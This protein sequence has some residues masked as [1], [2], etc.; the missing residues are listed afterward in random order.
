MH[1]PESISSFQ[2]G[3]LPCRSTLQQMLLFI[4]N[5]INAKAQRAP[6]DVIYLDIKKAF[7]TVSHTILL[8]KLKGYGIAGNLLLWFRAYLT[9]RIQ[10]VR[11]NDATSDFMPVTS[12]VPQG[13]ILGPLLFVL[14][15]N[16][17]PAA[18]KSAA[19]FLFADDTKCMQ[20]TKNT[21][22]IFLL[23]ADLNQIH[24]W[25]NTSDLFFNENKC[26]HLHFWDFWNSDVNYSIGNKLISLK[27]STKDLGI[28]ITNNLNWSLHYTHITTKSY[29]F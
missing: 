3:F 11:I 9:D 24:H 14:F 22:D 27:D 21:E 23:Q 18:A 15:I 25:S 17:L 7:D 5:L 2:F 6:V 29:K 12:G 28:I 16:D 4:D 26:V 8:Q 1:V 10:C 13:S 20:V 19:M